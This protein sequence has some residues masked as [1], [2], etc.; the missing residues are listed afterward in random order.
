MRCDVHILTLEHERKDWLQECLDSL[1]DEPATVHVLPGII[2]GQGESRANGF[3]AG[4]AEF[5]SYVDPDDRVEPGIFEVCFE[6]LDRNPELS[7][8]W[9]AQTFSL[10]DEPENNMDDLHLKQTQMPTYAFNI[11]HLVVLRR[12]AV[13]PYLERLSSWTGGCEKG[14]WIVMAD[15]G[16]QFEFIRKIGYHFRN[17]SDSARSWRKTD[18]EVQRI[19]TAYLKKYPT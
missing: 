18:P 4:S 10:V 15:E 12:T 7:G 3:R 8:V 17:R 16:H 9:T 11:H 2:N 1:K 5:V 19:F 14:L 13:E 6:V